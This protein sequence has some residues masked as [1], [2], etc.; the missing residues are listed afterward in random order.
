[1]KLLL[2]ICGT[3]TLVLILGLTCNTPERSRTQEMT[4][5]H[6]Y[7]SGEFP[8]ISFSYPSFPHWEP[9]LFH[10]KISYMPD[11]RFVKV[12]LEVAPSIYHTGMIKANR[13]VEWIEQFKKTAKKNPNGI[14]MAKSRAK[15]LGRYYFQVD[16]GGLYFEIYLEDWTEYGFDGKAI[17]VTVFETLQ[18]HDE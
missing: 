9:R 13:S 14:L 8:F 5:M 18:I 3:F 12:K 2:T 11:S 17:T 15:E 4:S 6:V 7:K 10:R 16:H 1:M